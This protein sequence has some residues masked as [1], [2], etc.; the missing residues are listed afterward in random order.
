MCSF[1]DLAIDHLLETSETLGSIVKR[2]EDRVP[3]ILLFVQETDYKILLTTLIIP[4]GQRKQG[5]GS[6]IMVDLTAY[7]DK[8]G[9]R[10][11]VSPGEKDP[12]YGTTSRG[13]L[14]KFYRRFGFV[15]NK[16]RSKDYRTSSTMLREPVVGV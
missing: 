6:Q 15:P 14:T 7:A 10:L 3:D 5:I 12:Y 13:R 16:G 2:W 8:V 4:R 1:V 11:E 9:K